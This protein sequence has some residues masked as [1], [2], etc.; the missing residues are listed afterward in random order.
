MVIM[1]LQNFGTSDRSLSPVHLYVVL[2]HETFKNIGDNRAQKV[3]KLL[4]A[5]AQ[6]EK[7]ED[8]LENRRKVLGDLS[9]KYLSSKLE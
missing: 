2:T 4:E 7:K 8:Y 6:K 5:I 3:S 9:K 1:T